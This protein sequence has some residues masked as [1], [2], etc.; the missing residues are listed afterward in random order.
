MSSYVSQCTKMRKSCEKAVFCLL[1]FSVSQ[2]WYSFKW[3]F[4]YNLNDAFRCYF[5]VTET[6]TQFRKCLCYLRTNTI[7]TRRII[8]SDSPLHFRIVIVHAKTT[9]W[10]ERQRMWHQGGIQPNWRPHYFVEWNAISLVFEVIKHQYIDDHRTKN[11]A[12]NM[13]TASS[14]LLLKTTFHFRSHC[15]S[16]PNLEKQIVS[17]RKWAGQLYF[18]A[19]IAKKQIFYENINAM[20]ANIKLLDFHNVLNS[21]C[22]VFPVPFVIVC[23]F[24]L[25]IGATI[26]GL[27]IIA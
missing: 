10:T 22:I 15:I 2:R 18:Y 20:R 11:Q 24:A 8:T 26:L 6:N 4:I 16:E 23:P 7:A 1:Y 21:D 9:K 25:A 3:L 27:Q 19:C 13:F 5:W 17:F 12:E 14:F